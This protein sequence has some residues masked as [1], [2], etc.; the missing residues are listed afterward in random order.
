MKE[1]HIISMEEQIVGFDGSRYFQAL[2]DI[3]MIVDPNKEVRKRLLKDME[4]MSQQGRAA[5]DIW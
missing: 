4:A 3:W 2:W 1:I 5:S